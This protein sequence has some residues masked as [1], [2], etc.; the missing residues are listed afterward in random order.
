[1]TRVNAVGLENSVRL[2]GSYLLTLV[3]IKLAGFDVGLLRGPLELVVEFPLSD[4]DRLRIHH[5]RHDVMLVLERPNRCALSSTITSTLFSHGLGDSGT[6]E[7]P[8]YPRA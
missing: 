7:V 1:M 2:L 4:P 8:V 6:Y 3:P 5:G